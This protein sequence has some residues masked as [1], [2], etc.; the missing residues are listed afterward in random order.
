[1]PQQHA[2]THLVPPSLPRHSTSAVLTGF[3]AVMSVLR[4]FHTLPTNAMRSRF[5]TRALTS[6]R[7]LLLALPRHLSTKSDKPKLPPFKFRSLPALI[8]VAFFALL[9]LVNLRALT[10]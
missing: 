6:P 9:A 8:C 1:M 3:P 2:P 5:M 7:C 10:P 4:T